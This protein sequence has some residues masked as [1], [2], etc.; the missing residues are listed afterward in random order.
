[1][2]YNRA[3]RALYLTMFGRI[4]VSHSLMATYWA[5][6]AKN[7]CLTEKNLSKAQTLINNFICDG[8]SFSGGELNLPHYKTVGW[9]SLTLEI[10]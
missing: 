6:Y 8:K 5:Y 1:M 2:G 7:L 4:N 3:Q 9:E 10:P